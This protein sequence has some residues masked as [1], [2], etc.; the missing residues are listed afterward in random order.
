MTRRPGLLAEYKQRRGRSFPEAETLTAHP[1]PH[2]SSCLLTGFLVLCKVVL[3]SVK[4][5]HLLRIPLLHGWP[6]DSVLANSIL[7]GELSSRGRHRSQ[8]LCPSG[9]PRSPS[10]NTNRNRKPRLKEVAPFPPGGLKSQGENEE[11]GASRRLHRCGADPPFPDFLFCKTKQSL[12]GQALHYSQLSPILPSHTNPSTVFTH[13]WG[14][15]TSAATMM[16][17]TSK[18]VSGLHFCTSVM[19]KM[20]IWWFNSSSRLPLLPPYF[21]EE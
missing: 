7:W 2:S 13:T 21:L 11:P 5:I 10:L 6:S 15:K 16:I 1:V 12:L 14:R 18:K 8:A 17:F 9:L 4:I 19:N 20:E 3:C